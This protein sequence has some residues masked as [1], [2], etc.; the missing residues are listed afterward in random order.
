MNL[1]G[2]RASPGSVPILFIAVDGCPG[3]QIASHVSEALAA[4]RDVE[5][6]VPELLD[7]E[8]LSM[9]RAFELIYP[10]RLFVA[11][12]RNGGWTSNARCSEIVVITVT[13]AFFSERPERRLAGDQERTPES[14]AFYSAEDGLTVA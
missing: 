14:L 3:R 1:V 13:D 5:L 8:L 4:G 11:S 10:A 6:L 9:W 7:V 2:R 12:T